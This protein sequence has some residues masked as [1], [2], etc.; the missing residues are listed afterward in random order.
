MINSCIV[1]TTTRICVAEDLSTRRIHLYGDELSYIIH[2]LVFYLEILYYFA[3]D[4]KKGCIIVIFVLG[5]L[6]KITWR[7]VQSFVMRKIRP[8]LVSTYLG[9]RYEMYNSVLYSHKVCESR[10]QHINNKL[11]ENYHDKDWVCKL[12]ESSITFFGLIQGQ[13]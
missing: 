8:W 6:R 13:N 12:G 4:W 3:P 7:G 2:C 9:V 10:K 5:L 1:L 11:T